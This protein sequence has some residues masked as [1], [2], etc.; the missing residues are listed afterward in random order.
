MFL[1]LG[2]VEFSVTPEF[3]RLRT[4]VIFRLIFGVPFLTVGGALNAKTNADSG[5]PSDFWGRH[6]RVAS[7]EV[8]RTFILNRNIKG[9]NLYR[10]Y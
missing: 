3:S 6:D 4:G 2:R 5:G 10:R 8:S 9:S 7:H 1:V